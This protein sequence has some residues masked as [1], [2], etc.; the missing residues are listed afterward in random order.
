MSVMRM[1]RS[2]LVP[3]S[4]V[5]LVFVFDAISTQSNDSKEATSA[6][7]SVST[8]VTTP[9]TTPTTVVGPTG[10]QGETGSSGPIG[11]QGPTGATGDR[12]PAGPQGL[13]GP[14]GEVGPVG[15]QGPTGPKGD[16]G[17]TGPQGATGATGLQG[18]TG[19]KGDT[20]ATGAIGPQGPTGP[21]GDTGATG[22]QGATGDAGPQGPHG[23]TGETGAPGPQGLQGI[24]GGFGDYGSFY[25]TTSTLLPQNTAVAV[26]L[27]TTD[28]THGVTVATDTDGKPTKITFATSG[29][30]NVAFSMQLGK[31]DSGTDLVSIWLSMNGE[32]VPNSSTDLYL[33][34]SDLKSRSVAAW[35]FFVV[36]TPGDFIQLMI[37][38]SNDLK[39]SILALPAQSN[40]PR[41]EIPSTILTVNQVG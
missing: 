16:T 36:A 18:A 31:T 40:P 22:P 28:A 7:S 27:N 37:A 6:S 4:I 29:I 23:P 20:G 33:S 21:K 8:T 1:L 5:G 30:Y 38:A 10:P 41:P 11:P 34:D 17:A 24:P 9:L 35:N 2:L 14:Q 25:D 3:T 39:T 15:P 13:V 26:P 32:N 12:G 19:Q